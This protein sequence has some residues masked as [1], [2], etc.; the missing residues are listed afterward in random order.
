M[1][2]VV[3]GDGKAGVSEVGVKQANPFYNPKT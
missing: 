3:A 2:K 1:R